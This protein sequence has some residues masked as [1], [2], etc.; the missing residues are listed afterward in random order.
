MIII[1]MFY[2]ISINHIST[3]CIVIVNTTYQRI[4]ATHQR[5]LN[6]NRA[7]IRRVD[8]SIQYNIKEEASKMH[9][10]EDV[11]NRIDNVSETEN[12]E[13]LCLSN[14]TFQLPW[15][16]T[17][18][19][20]NSIHHNIIVE[21]SHESGQVARTGR[22]YSEVDLHSQSSGGSTVYTPHIPVKQKINVVSE[23]RKKDVTQNSNFGIVRFIILKFK[24]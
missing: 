6:Q 2:M 22:S 3:F 1:I 16:T 20:N 4:I 23:N 18:V 21:T 10:Y 11:L 17:P 15:L 13:Y 14:N 12:Q 5:K 9:I 7:H 8:K 24:L 19:P